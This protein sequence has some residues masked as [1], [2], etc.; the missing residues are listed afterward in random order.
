[1]TI[2]TPEPHRGAY[3]LAEVVIVGTWGIVLGAILAGIF[4]C[5]KGG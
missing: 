5:V 3:L 2:G 1:M 4:L